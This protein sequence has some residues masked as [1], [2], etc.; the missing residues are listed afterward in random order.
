MDGFNSEDRTPENEQQ[1]NE[2]GQPESPETLEGVS[3]KISEPDE[4]LIASVERAFES[5]TVAE[6]QVDGVIF[7]LIGLD[8]LPMENLMKLAHFKGKRQVMLMRQYARLCLVNP[9]QWELL[10]NLKLQEFTAFA[11]GWILNSKSIPMMN[12]GND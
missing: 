3:G 2:S 5:I 11:Q 7:S 12:K 4:E 6:I 10:E 9:S 1:D 8:E